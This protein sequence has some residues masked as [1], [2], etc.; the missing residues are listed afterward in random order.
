ME[1]ACLLTPLL[2][3]IQVKGRQMRIFEWLSSNKYQIHAIVIHRAL[4]RIADVD[5]YTEQ[6]VYFS[7]SIFRQSTISSGD[8]KRTSKITLNAMNPSFQLNIFTQLSTSLTWL[9]CSIPVIYLFV[10][11]FG[12]FAILFCYFASV[13]PNETVFVTLIGILC[14]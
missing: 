1:M 7:S 5:G 4:C 6:W 12:N 10:I 3:Y 13:Q 11:H 14:F 2:S 8:L 9:R